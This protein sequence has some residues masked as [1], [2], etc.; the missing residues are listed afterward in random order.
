M[1]NED[2]LSEPTFGFFNEK[3][4]IPEWPVIKSLWSTEKRKA[5]WP[6]QQS[7][8]KK[9]L[10]EGLQHRAWGGGCSWLRLWETVP[11][12]GHLPPLRRLPQ[13]LQVREACFLT[14]FSSQSLFSCSLAMLLA[15][16]SDTAACSAVHY[17]KFTAPSKF[18]G[19]VLCQAA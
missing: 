15:C 1:A 7:L 6:Q 16:Q 19:K 18:S 14:H 12:C 9:R 3:K 8:S 11:C 2:F 5:K 17:N 4:A 10:D 13:R